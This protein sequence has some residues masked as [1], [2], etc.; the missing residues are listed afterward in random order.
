MSGA[1]LNL[2]SMPDLVPFLDCTDPFPRFMN[3]LIHFT[4]VPPLI[5]DS[6]LS[7]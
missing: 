1:I 2:S 6:T 5:F 7:S 4:A 3:A